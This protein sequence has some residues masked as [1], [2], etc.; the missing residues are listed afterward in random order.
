MATQKH[1]LLSDVTVAAEKYQLISYVNYNGDTEI[2]IN[3]L[4][5]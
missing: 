4:L 2:A 1:K 3:K 5:P